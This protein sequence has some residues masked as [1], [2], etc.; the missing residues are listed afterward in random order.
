VKVGISHRNK[1]GLGIDTPLHKKFSSDLAA[2]NTNKGEKYYTLRPRTPPY[3][4]KIEQKRQHKIQSKGENCNAAAREYRRIEKSCS[5]GH[6]QCPWKNLKPGQNLLHTPAA[7]KTPLHEKSSA[8]TAAKNIKQGRNYNP[9][10]RK[11][12]ARAISRV[13]GRNF[14]PVSISTSSKIMSSP[15]P[16]EAAIT[17]WNN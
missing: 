4:R 12:T 8:E 13:L 10:A 3:T 11:Y 1:Q 5:K 9:A 14:E 6:Q 7:K 2:S 15:T 16:T 17:Q